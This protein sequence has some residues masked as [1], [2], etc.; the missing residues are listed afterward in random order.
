MR[1]QSP[2]ASSSLTLVATVEI[3]VEVRLMDDR[4]VR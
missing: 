2:P 1:I 3:A 4:A